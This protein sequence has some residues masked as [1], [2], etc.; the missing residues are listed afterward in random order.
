MA[1]DIFFSRV[2]ANITR[3]RKARRMTQLEFAGRIDMNRNLLGRLERGQQNSNLD[4]LRRVAIG[5]EVPVGALFEGIDLD[6]LRLS[7]GY[8]AD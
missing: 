5:L 3:L 6:V 8:E 1:E 4:T 7:L 2:G